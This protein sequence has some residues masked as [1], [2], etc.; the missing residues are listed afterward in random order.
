MEITNEERFKKIIELVEGEE[1][2]MPQTIGMIGE[3]LGHMLVV[4]K[5]QEKRLKE[6]ENIHQTFGK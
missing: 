3:I 4:M 1:L 2:P 6:L 5:D